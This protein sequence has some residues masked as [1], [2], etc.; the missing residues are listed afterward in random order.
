VV[1]LGHHQDDAAET[2]M[3]KYK[4]LDTL[5]DAYSYLAF[6]RDEPDEALKLLE[7]GLPIKD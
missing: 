5:H 1:A 6:L 7:R 3:M 2:L 4:R